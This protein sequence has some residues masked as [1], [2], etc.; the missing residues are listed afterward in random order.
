[1]NGFFL[2]VDWLSLFLAVF[3]FPPLL[4]SIFLTLAHT[5]ALFTSIYYIQYV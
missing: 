5:N 3:F 2:L 1:V 4:S